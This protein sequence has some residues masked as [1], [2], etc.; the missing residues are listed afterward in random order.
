MGW[1]VRAVLARQVRETLRTPGLPWVFGVAGLVPA[2]AVL[3][4][5]AALHHFGVSPAGPALLRA[6]FLP[7]FALVGAL[8]SAYA[9]ASIAGRAE[10]GVVDA[11]RRHGVVVGRVLG[12]KLAAAVAL[13]FALLVITLPAGLLP[14]AFGQVPMLDATFALMGLSGIA[15]LGPAIGLALGAHIGEVKRSVAVATAL[16]ALVP[17]ALVFYARLAPAAL[18]GSGEWSALALFGSDD[19]VRRLDVYGQLAAL[20]L[21]AAFAILAVCRWIA[22]SALLPRDADRLGA[23]R[24][25]VPGLL[26][27]VALAVAFIRLR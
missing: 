26:A 24:R 27:I 11:M 1:G 23:L 15:I 2:A 13:G 14:L 10:A 12:G 9:A 17:V 18:L 21:L 5:A 22:V 16:L 6:W 4:A 19:A 25:W 3:A 7:S 8:S 20:P